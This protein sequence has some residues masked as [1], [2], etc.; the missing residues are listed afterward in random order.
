MTMYNTHIQR[1]NQIFTA[2]VSSIEYFYVLS[3]NVPTLEEY[4]AELSRYIWTLNI[5]DL[6]NMES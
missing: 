6:R 2:V 5:V 3:D 4:N 1:Q